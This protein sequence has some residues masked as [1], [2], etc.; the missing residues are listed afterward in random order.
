MS[1]AAN[2]LLF[3]ESVLVQDGRARV[4]ISVHRTGGRHLSI[5]AADSGVSAKIVL[6]AADLDRVIDLLRDAQAVQS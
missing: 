4:E 2:G 1:R 5:E 6:S 3:L